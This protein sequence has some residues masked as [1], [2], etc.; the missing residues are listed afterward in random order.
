[1]LFNSKIK[2]LKALSDATRLRIVTMLSRENLC[3]CQILE[4]FDLSQAT[5]SYHMK[6]L[7]DSGLVS[8]KKDGYWTRYSLNKDFLLPL[9][10]LLDQIAEEV[11]VKSPEILCGRTHETK[12]K[13]HS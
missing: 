5:L 13:S 10:E 12:T 4:E 1:M 8:G 6:Q 9:V 7:Q 11:D 2:I 3:S